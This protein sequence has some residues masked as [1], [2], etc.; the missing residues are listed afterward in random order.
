MTLCAEC[1]V[2]LGYKGKPDYERHVCAFCGR[3][4]FGYIVKEESGHEREVRAVQ[5]QFPKL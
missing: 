3:A 5:R 2:K 1:A 4:A